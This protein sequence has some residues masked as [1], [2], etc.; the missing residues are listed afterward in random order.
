MSEART[1]FYGWLGNTLEHRSGLVI[2]LIVIITICLMYPFSQMAPEEQASDNPTGNDIVQLSDHIEDTFLL[3]VFWVGFIVEAHEGDVLTREKLAELYERT[4][5]LKQSDLAE[6]LYVFYDEAAGMTIEGIYTIADAVN[7]ALLIQSGGA[8]DIFSE[9]ITDEQIKLIIEFLMN[10]PGAEQFHEG[11]SSLYEHDEENGIWTS[12][13]LIVSVLTSDERVLADYLDE[14]TAPEEADIADKTYARESFA[15]EVQEIMRS[16]EIENDVFGVAL[17]LEHEIEEEGMI[18]GIMLFAALILMAI[19]LLIIFR[20]FIIMVLTVGGLGMLIIWLK[21]LS[22]LIG[23]KGSMIIDII[24]PVAIVVL[25]VDYAIQALF[26]YREQRAGGDDA[27]KALGNSTSRVGRALVLAMFTTIVAFISNATAEIE[28]VIGFAVAAS[29]AIF[30]SFVLLGLFVP[31]LNMKWRVWRS[32]S[33]T[34]DIPAGAGSRVKWLGNAVTATSDRWKI[35]LPVAIIITAF[36][37]WGW[38]NVETKMDA[39][40]ALKSNSDFVVGLDKWD[41]HGADKGGEPSV[42]YFKGDLTRLE[43]IEAI[44]ETINQM[45]REDEE[46]Y[47]GNDPITGKANANSLLLDILEVLIQNEYA[48]DRITEATGVEISDENGDLIPDSQEQLQA[49]YDYVIENGLPKDESMLRY[50]PRQI[51]ETFVKLNS[52]DYATTMTVGVPGTREQSIVRFSE[53]QLKKDMEIALGGVESISK[54]GITGSGNVRVVQFDAIADA[55]TSSLIIAIAAVMLILLIIFRSVR[56]AVLTIIPVL[57]V[58]TWLYGFMYIAGYSLNMLTATIAAISIGVG[59]DFS[60][61]FTERFREEI[62]NGLDK[63]SAI[64]KTAQSTGFALFCTALTTMLG[65]A[66]IAFA[67]MPMFSTFGILTAIMIVLALLMALFVLPSLLHVFVS[68]PVK[69]ETKK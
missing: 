61:H 64:Q 39:S 19:L 52:G 29:I 24:L 35:V 18:G 22:N 23:L 48:Q 44:Y 27:C 2:A 12:P 67:P 16:N 30:A 60:I 53:E 40:D 10:G 57:L 65:F 13:A 32:K 43:A 55:L 42:L 63:R 8:Q 54:Y 38:T 50:R 5:A 36:A 34:S 59:I 25:G 66:V 41:V 6:Y 51:A 15:L 14:G 11:L 17:D 9:D 47:V 45:N 62:S 7:E 28:S 4:E 26:R 1:G 46:E 37:A 33:K 68:E 56:Y 69:S 49:V 58:A 3:D 21:G 31:T 20:S